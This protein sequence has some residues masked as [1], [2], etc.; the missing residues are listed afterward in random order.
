MTTSCQVHAVVSSAM[1][2]TVHFSEVAQALDTAALT[3]Q[4][5]V[6]C[7]GSDTRLDSGA[8]FIETSRS[9]RVASPRHARTRRQ[10]DVRKRP[11]AHASGRTRGAPRRDDGRSRTIPSS[12]RQSR[13]TALAG[14]VRSWQCNR[15][16]MRLPG[17]S[18]PAGAPFRL[19]SPDWE[20]SRLRDRGFRNQRTDA[21]PR[22]L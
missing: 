22:S 12:P 9:S 18:F 7:Q 16:L 17:E 10:G 5:T 2:Q 19:M 3:R 21:P 15:Q 14:R 13:G 8:S 6:R 20:S 4:M 1:S 11:A